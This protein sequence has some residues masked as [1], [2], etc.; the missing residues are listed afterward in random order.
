MTH[1]SM[2]MYNQVSV[3]Q[4][5]HYPPLIWSESTFYETKISVERTYPKFG[6]SGSCDW[7]AL[8]NIQ[9]KRDTVRTISYYKATGPS[10]Q[11]PH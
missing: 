2:C 6:G 9:Q 11:E 10:G 8:T 5:T 3:C 1:E 7:A 4:Q